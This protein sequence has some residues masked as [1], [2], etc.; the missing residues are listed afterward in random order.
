MKI[1]GNL[2]IPPPQIKETHMFEEPNAQI[3]QVEQDAVHGEEH[4]HDEY[5]THGEVPMHG[6]H[7]SHEE[8]SSQRGPP[9]WFLEYIGKLNEKMKKD[10][11]APRGNTSKPREARV[12]H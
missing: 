12:I 3:F 8:T 1:E 7:P 9:T 4:M 11:A 10:R 6:G 2:E 5:P